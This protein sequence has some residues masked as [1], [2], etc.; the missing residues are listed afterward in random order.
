MP[1]ANRVSQFKKIPIVAAGARPWKRLHWQRRAFQ[2]GF[3]AL[4]LFIPISGLFRIDPVDGAFVVLDRQIWFSD[5][6]IV[7]GF[8]LA[9]ASGLV[10]TYSMVGTA[11]C[12][13]A[14]PQNTISEWANRLTRKLLGRR[15]EVALNGEKM[16][17]SAG[18]NSAGNWMLLGLTLLIAAMFFALIP[19][20]YFY[21]PDVVWSFV[22]LQEDAR[23]AASLH[24]IYAI[25]VAI[26]LLDIAFIRHFFCRFMCIYKVWQHSFKTKQTLHITYD[27]SRA[28]ECEKCNFCVTTCVVAIDPRRT[29]TFDACINCGECITACNNL[30]ERKAESGLLRFEIGERAEDLARKFRT[31]LA[32]F[33]G[34]VHWTLPFTALG[35]LMFVWGLLTYE[36]QHLSVYRDEHNAAA[37]VQDYR[38][39]LVNKLYR[40]ARVTLTVAGLDAANFVLSAHKVAFNSADRDDVILHIE[41]SL[42]P[43]IYTVLVH[44]ESDAGWRQ[45]YRIQ[46]FVE[47][48]ARG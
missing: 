32:S 20:F 36:P 8:W 3:I 22:T 5:F 42:P 6:F 15:A 35:L 40:P 14:C 33:V 45:S 26:V 30:H 38:I 21:P 46:H 41:P 11:F 24:Y 28:A 43:G 29:D 4:L 25:F 23:L 16:K 37:A 2:F 47:K 1:E 34:R 27:K 13:W 39:H 7:F 9:V 19:M 12:G 44:A 18:K 48:A 10:L 31:N 17:V